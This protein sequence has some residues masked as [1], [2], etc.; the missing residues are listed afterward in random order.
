MVFFESAVFPLFRSSRNVL[1][2]SSRDI[3]GRRQL[4]G[5]LKGSYLYDFGVNRRVGWLLIASIFWRW[6]GGKGGDMYGFDGA[7]ITA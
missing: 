5:G 3:K 4:R 2:S 6:R 7:A 1:L